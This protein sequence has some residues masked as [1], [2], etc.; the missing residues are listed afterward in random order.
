MHREFSKTRY[1]TLL[2]GILAVSTLAL[3]PVPVLAASPSC[4]DT[5][6]VS[7]T[8]RAD[9]GPCSGDGLTIGASN[10]TLNCAGHTIAGMGTDLSVLGVVLDGVTGVTVRNCS[11]NG[12]IEGFRV[13]FSSSN[14][15]VGN[16]ASGNMFGFF[17]SSS[18]GNTFIG[19]TAD[20]NQIGIDVVLSS[21][22]AFKGNTANSNSVSGFSSESSILN[23]FTGNT[24]DNNGPADRVPYSGIGFSFAFSSNGNNFTG[25]T[26]NGNVEWGF[27][28]SASSDNHFRGNT[29][30]NNGLDGFSI[31]ATSF[32]GGGYSSNNRLQGNTANGNGLY[33]YYDSS[34]GLGTAGTSNSYRGDEC[35]DNF[36]GG[37]TPTGLCAPQP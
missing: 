31:E 22:N 27:R 35:N 28:V 14:T 8:L 37:S 32:L 11:V 34:R 19:N 9:V 1:A 13:I 29:A 6:T 20:N 26:A 12:F 3:L 10:I 30:N 4:G 5:I 21:G 23:T 16:T 36:E 15:L 7:T 2:L 18:Q 17:T 33:G 25:N 24:A